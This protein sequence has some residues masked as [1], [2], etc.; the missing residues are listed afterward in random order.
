M[1][2]NFGGISGTINAVKLCINENYEQKLFI[3]L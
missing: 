1:V 3:R 2:R